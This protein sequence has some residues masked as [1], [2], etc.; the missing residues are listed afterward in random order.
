[1]LA[2]IRKWGS[3]IRGSWPTLRELEALKLIE[4]DAAATVDE[5]VEAEIAED[6]GEPPP[7]PGFG[8][9]VLTVAGERA[10]R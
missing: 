3:P 5:I 2:E 7:D 10:L 6:A 9:W 8:Q 4:I 1:M